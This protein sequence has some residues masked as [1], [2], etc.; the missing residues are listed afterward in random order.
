MLKNYKMLLWRDITM[1]HKILILIVCL[2][3][4]Y[5]G[6]SQDDKP[7]PLFSGESY[8]NNTLDT[9]WLLHSTA[10]FKKV[11]IAL[12]NQKSYKKEIEKYK[13]LVDSMNLINIE[14]IEYIDS[15]K[16]ERLYYMDLWSKSD[17][18]VEMLAKLNNKQTKFTRWAI[19]IGSTTTVTAFI[20]GLFLGLK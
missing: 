12:N 9:M 5:F 19:V 6:I 17:K 18:D 20:V 13:Q 11:S 1:N 16:K 15:L 8:T 4:P 2:I 3:I 14:Q 10:Q 7:I